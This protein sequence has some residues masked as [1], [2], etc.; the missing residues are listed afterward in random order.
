MIEGTPIMTV[1]SWPM[2]VS[3]AQFILLL[4]SRFARRD[5]ER[6]FNRRWIVNFSALDYGGV[7]VDVPNVCCRVAVDENHVSEFPWSDEAAIFIHTHYQGRRPSCHAQ[8]FSR[9]NTGAHIKL[10]FVV[11]RVAGE[12]IG[13][14][15]NRHAGIINFF[16]QEQHCREGPVVSRLFVWWNLKRAAPHRAP[17]LRRKTRHNFCQARRDRAGIAAKKRFEN[18]YGRI[19]HGA[20]VPEEINELAHFG[21]VRRKFPSVLSDFGKSI[22]IARFLHFRKQEIEHDKV[23]VLDFVS[24]AFD[25][26][27]C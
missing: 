20:I 7:V 25:E 8:N 15:N 6:F 19:E 22:A 23:Q 4:P 27:T 24:A 12:R 1:A 2:A 9:R 26:L 17:Y 3:I 5:T 13:S 14:W 18:V 21:C 10:Q 16:E 11:K